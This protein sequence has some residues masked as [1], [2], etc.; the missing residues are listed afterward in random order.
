M[1]SNIVFLCFSIGT[2][3]DKP[4]SHIIEH[5]SINPGRFVNREK[6]YEIKRGSSK[7]RINV[8]L[9]NQFG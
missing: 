2:M 3:D 9:R 1:D 7:L 8:A 4:Q 5:D 6:P